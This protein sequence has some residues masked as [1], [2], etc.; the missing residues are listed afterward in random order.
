MTNMLRD[1][2]ADG[3]GQK[4]GVFQKNVTECHTA[5][6]MPTAERKDR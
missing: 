6:N 3:E 5:R 1:T 4:G 2:D